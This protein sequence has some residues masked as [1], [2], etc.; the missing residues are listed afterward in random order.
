MGQTTSQ[1]ESQI[2][3]H[4]IELIANF[5]MWQETGSGIN[6]TKPLKDEV[7]KCW[8]RFNQ[9]TLRAIDMS[10]LIQLLTTTNWMLTENYIRNN[11]QHAKDIAKLL[12][13]YERIN[14]KNKK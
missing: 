1:I 9:K 13:D 10:N 12:V 5:P 14:K 6:T 4:F 8:A 3:K 11:V 2:E 7:D